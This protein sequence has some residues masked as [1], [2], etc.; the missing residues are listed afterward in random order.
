MELGFHSDFFADLLSRT[1]WLGFENDHPHFW[2]AQ[3][4]NEPIIISASDHRVGS[5]AARRE[6]EKLEIETPDGLEASYYA[7]FGPHIRLPA[8][9]YRGALEIIIEDTASEFTIDAC[10]DAGSKILGLKRGST[11][12]EFE[13]TEPANDVEVRLFVKGGFRATLEYISL[14]VLD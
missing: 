7:V 1:G 3:R 6:N 12:L 13:L 14:T 10:C 9:R 4:K 8:G 11:S 2:S 5:Q